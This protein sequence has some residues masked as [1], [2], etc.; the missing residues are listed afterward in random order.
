MY[1]DMD[2]RSRL[3]EELE[4]MSEGVETLGAQLCSD[5][6]LVSKHMNSLQDLDL[7]AQIQRCVAEVL[8]ATDFR[9]A[10]ANCSLA[11]LAGR[12]VGQGDAVERASTVADCD[13][14]PY[15]DPEV[16]F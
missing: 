1:M 6:V 2:M 14:D 8:R 15:D 11:D 3:A 4:R 9:D 12:L 7:L 16:F 5:P 10:A 13:P